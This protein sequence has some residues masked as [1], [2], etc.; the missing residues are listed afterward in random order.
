MTPFE[1][2]LG[3]SFTHFKSGIW[4]EYNAIT[5]QHESHLKST[6][7]AASQYWAIFRDT[8]G[9]EWVQYDT[10]HLSRSAVDFL[11]GYIEIE[12]LLEDNS[13]Q[14]K[15][16]ACRN[17]QRQLLAANENCQAYLGFGIVSG[18]E[19]I[20]ELTVKPNLPKEAFPQIYP[21]K[22]PP[23]EEKADHADAQKPKAPPAPR[24]P[25]SYAEEVAMRS[26]NPAAFPPALAPTTYKDGLGYPTALSQYV[27]PDFKLY[28]RKQD[29]K[30]MSSNV[31][32]N[33]IIPDFTVTTLDIA[34]V[35][36]Q[37]PQQTVISL[38]IA[39][40]YDFLHTACS[41]YKDIVHQYSERFNLAPHV[42]LAL[43]HT[44]SQF[45]PFA[46]SY[47]PAYGLMQLV[48]STGGMDAHYYLYNTKQKPSIEFLYNPSNNI[49]F[50]TAY[51]SKVKD[52]YFGG[53]ENEQNAYMASIAAYNTGIGNVAKALVGTVNLKEAVQVINTMAPNQL[54][55]A[56]QKYLPRN[57]TKR[58][59]NYIMRRS[60]LYFGPEW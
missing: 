34:E 29:D 31:V 46:R 32:V 7:D 40:P 56:L 15:Q 9:P 37:F 10:T 33:H 36:K 1:A 16:K 3:T 5:G 57:E 52:V 8:R 49:L 43:T 21:P 4:Q 19:G 28:T 24:K 13:P 12:T 41:Q 25:Q 22:K 18:L 17:L 54:Y 20:V 51:F 14:A 55:E 6:K 59:L 58:Y 23:K 47:A 35:Q 42:M 39:L 45:N 38:K 2:T 11:R 30:G 48:P 44:E 60:A 53:I 50:G 26:A 27:D